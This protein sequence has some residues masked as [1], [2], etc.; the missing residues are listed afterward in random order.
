MSPPSNRSLGQDTDMGGGMGRF[1]FFVGK[2]S[3]RVGKYIPQVCF[4][5][6][7]PIAIL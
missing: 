7:H 2:G 3:L 6:H 4:Q 1:V 5:Y